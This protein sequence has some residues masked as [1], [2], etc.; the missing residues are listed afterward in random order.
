MCS[1]NLPK[2]LQEELDALV[3]FEKE[4]NTAVYIMNLATFKPSQSEEWAIDDPDDPEGHLWF[5]YVWAAGRG[6]ASYFNVEVSPATYDSLGIRFE[7]IKKGGRRTVSYASIA[8]SSAT[9]SDCFFLRATDALGVW[10][11]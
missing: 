6:P 11:Y 9:R 7:N 5:I 4:K 1:H 8:P 3:K 10:H 2:T